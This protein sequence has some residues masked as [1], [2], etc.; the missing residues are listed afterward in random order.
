MTKLKLNHGH[1]A[2]NSKS[3]LVKCNRT[4][5]LQSSSTRGSLPSVMKQGS[6][7]SA[8]LT[9]PDGEVVSVG[10]SVVRSSVPAQIVENES[11][12]SEDVLSSTSGGWFS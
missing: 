9:M 6:R 11:E 3:Q 7:I 10:G 5:P 2:K 8:S 12:E 1:F 4:N